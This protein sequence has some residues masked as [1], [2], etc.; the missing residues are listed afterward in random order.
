MS[1]HGERPCSYIVL[2]ILPALAVLLG[3]KLASAFLQRLFDNV[4]LQL[5]DRRWEDDEKTHNWFI[6]QRDLRPPS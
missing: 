6:I 4:R 5:K 3:V 2:Q 1:K